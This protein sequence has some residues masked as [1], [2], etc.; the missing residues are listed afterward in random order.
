VLAQTRSLIVGVV[1]LAVFGV[2]SILG[3]VLMSALIGLPFVLTS[4][5]L[6]G[7]HYSLQT[8]AGA[9]S[10]MFG[11]WYA[12]TTGIVGELWKTL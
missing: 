2:G 7:I 12:Y 3:M 4:G 11:V 8:V 5:R 10:I 1:Y 9:L 6:S